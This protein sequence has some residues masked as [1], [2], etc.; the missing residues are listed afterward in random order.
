MSFTEPSFTVGIEEEY[1]LVDPA[2]RDV[3]REPPNA[4][5]GECEKRLGDLVRPE[6]LRSQ[7]EVGTRVCRTVPEARSELVRLR[8]CVSDVAQSFGFAMIAAS[9]HPFAQWQDQVHTNK[10]RYNILARD[11]QAVARRLLICGMHVHVGIDDDELRIDLLNQV[12][13]FLPYLLALST[14]SPF[15]MGENTGLKS[16]RLSVFDELPRT[17]LPEPF[18]SYMEY[19]RHVDILVR[20]GLIDDATM[21]WWDVRPSV[22]Y[23]RHARRDVARQHRKIV[24]QGLAVV[25]EQLADRRDRPVQVFEQRA[26]A[27]LRKLGHIAG[28]RRHRGEDVG[29]VF[30]LHLAAGI[31]RALA[32]AGAEADRER[33][34]QTRRGDSGD[35]VLGD[36][37]TSPDGVLDPKTHPALGLLGRD[38]LHLTDRIPLVQNL[39]HYPTRLNHLTGVNLRRG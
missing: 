9:T 23:L 30:A 8:G 28:D 32:R 33:R 20:A 31:E 36:P 1:L 21:L 12:G 24:Q 34:K 15:W 39:E 7:I 37:A 2:T 5:L 4:M 3:V 25:V 10:A 6:F 13:Y 17:G 22:R 35:A 18:S 29:R 27:G 16:Y 26:Q 38:A 19:S 14:S 11:M